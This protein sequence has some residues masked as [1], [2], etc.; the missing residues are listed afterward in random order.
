MGAINFQLINELRRIR[1]I[2]RT[3]KKMQERHG[4]AIS[5]ELGLF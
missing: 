1:A 2:V 5:M 3:A 4:N